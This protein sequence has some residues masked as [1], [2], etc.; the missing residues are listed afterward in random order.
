[1][2]LEQGHL[3]IVS[4]LL[5]YG[6]KTTM[7]HVKSIKRR[8]KRTIS[9]SIIEAI[10]N[11]NA[12][13]LIPRSSRLQTAFDSLWTAVS[14]G[15]LDTVLDMLNGAHRL[16]IGNVDSRGCSVLFAACAFGHLAIVKAL[17]SNGAAI[18]LRNKRFVFAASFLCFVQCCRCLLTQRDSRVIKNQSIHQYAF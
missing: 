1:M 4:L 3:K 6:A 17:V 7:A 10:R 9:S 8:I 15:A 12:L 5:A 18:N 16:A 13:K 11:A 2:G 14:S